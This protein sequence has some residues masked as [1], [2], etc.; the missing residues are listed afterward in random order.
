VQ[1]ISVL[2]VGQADRR[3]FLE[4]RNTLANSASLRLAPDLAT[5]A[6]LV[7]GESFAPEVIVLAEAYPGQFAAA[8][9]DR[10][11]AAAPLARVVAL[12]GSWCEGET[13]T[14]RPLPGAVRLYW[15]QARPRV[16]QELARVAAGQV[17]SWSLPPTATEEERLLA[18]AEEPI[19]AAHGLVAIC[20]PS[21][22]T[23][24]WLSATCRLAGYATVRWNGPRW[25]EVTGATGG[26][27]DATDLGPLEAEQLA[28][29]ARHLGRTPIVALLDFPRVED[30]D[31]A[32]ACGA[33]AVL[34]KPLVLEDLLWLLRDGR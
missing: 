12:L 23:A 3:E 20:A 21:A 18:T 33:A 27:F 4:T 1:S 2:F 7:R 11:R 28:R 13:R 17:S 19:P 16:V 26:I 10:L 22:V 5:A 8:A 30:R 14:G 29:M 32:L 25:P 15:H 24:D 31:R 6:A 34:S 9:I